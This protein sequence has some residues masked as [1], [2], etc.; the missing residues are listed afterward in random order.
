MAT[1]DGG[2]IAEYGPL[3]NSTRMFRAA[4]FDANGNATGRL[5]NLPMYSWTGSAYQYG[6]VEQ[7][8]PLPITYAPTFA[9]MIAGNS[10]GTR[11]AIQ[12]VQTNKTQG[13]EEQVPSGSATLHTNYNSIELLT[14]QSPDQIFSQ[15]IETF[16]GLQDANNQKWFAWGQNQD[17]ANVPDG[18]NVTGAC[19]TVTFTLLRFF[20]SGPVVWLGLGQ[21]P[22]SV[23]VTQVSAET[24]TLKGH[25]LAGWRYWRAFSVGTNDVVVE[26]GAA[27]TSGPG[28]KNYAGY[29]IFQGRQTKLWQEDFQYILSDLRERGLAQQGS[30]PAYNIVKG[31][32]GYDQTYIMSH[33]IQHLPNSCGN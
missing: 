7:V 3:D 11:T 12:Q 5:G 30:N 28:L 17:L 4:T 32:W 27:D 24:D 18:T 6:S 31:K 26:T 9:A 1:A 13:S 23:G 14:T 33:I 29:Y 10:S 2:V 15:Y 19:Q 16:A 22:F 8:V 25:P 21:G 20:G